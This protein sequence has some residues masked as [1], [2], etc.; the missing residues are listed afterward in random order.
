[1]TLTSTEQ[2][3]VFGDPA[4]PLDRRQFPV[5]AEKRSVRFAR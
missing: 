4:G 5:G 2:A 3:E 1:M